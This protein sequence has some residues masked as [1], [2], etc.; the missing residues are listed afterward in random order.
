MKKNVFIRIVLLAIV[1]CIALSLSSCSRS[2]TQKLTALC[3]DGEITSWEELDAD[4]QIDIIQ[5]FGAI[6]EAYTLERSLADNICDYG[7]NVPFTCIVVVFED[8]ADAKSYEE[9]YSPNSY[10]I[11]MTDTSTEYFSTVTQDGS[12]TGTIIGMKPTVDITVSGDD[13]GLVQK[14]LRIKNTVILGDAILVE[15]VYNEFKSII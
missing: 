12:F 3:E 7:I 8:E 4:K 15:R 14:A 13:G 10:I 1:I 9:Q 11:N 5:K 2:T 6:S